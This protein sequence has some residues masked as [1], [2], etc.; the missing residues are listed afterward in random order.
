MAIKTVWHSRVP[1]AITLNK[2]KIYIDIN[3][4]KHR[5]FDLQKQGD[6]AMPAPIKIVI[7]LL[8]IVLLIKAVMP[9]VG[10]HFV[11][12]ELKFI[13]IDELPVYI[14]HLL[15]VHSACFATLG[16]FGINYLR[17]KR[18]LSSVEPILVFGIFLVFFYLTLIFLE[19]RMSWESFV[20]LGLLVILAFFLYKENQAETR[21]IFKDH[22]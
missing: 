11:P 21:T 3:N 20:A 12:S 15:I 16:Y 22:W 7:G 14:F 19:G 18:P 4:K 1:I 13:N 9:L 17:R 8:A 5:P 2:W 6:K 10:Y